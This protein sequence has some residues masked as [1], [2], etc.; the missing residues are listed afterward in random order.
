MTMILAALLAGCVDEPTDTGIAAD[1]GVD[2]QTD[3]AP[4]TSLVGQGCESPRVYDSKIGAGN[5]AGDRNRDRKSGGSC[6]PTMGCTDDHRLLHW[7]RTECPA[8][9]RCQ[10]GG[11][12]RS[13]RH[14]GGWV[15]V[16]ACDTEYYCPA[17]D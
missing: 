14:D 5:A 4:D 9:H 7:C 2:A 10:P 1:T 8:T 13:M 15:V 12:W 11:S 16:F 17:N 6:T 3:V